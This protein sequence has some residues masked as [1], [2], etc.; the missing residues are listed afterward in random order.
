MPKALIR[1]IAR[2]LIQHGEG[3]EDER[4]VDA[5]TENNT[6][7]TAEFLDTLRAA[8]ELGI[9]ADGK[10]WDELVEITIWKTA[11]GRDRR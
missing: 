7:T 11:G 5:D 9:E 10:L 1:R 8:E 6:V 4:D 3:L 2:L